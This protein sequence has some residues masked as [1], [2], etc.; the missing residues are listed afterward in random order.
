[1]V[2]EFENGALGSFEASRFATGRKNFNYFEIYGDKGAL[3]FDLE[4]MNEL[5][6]FSSDDPT[7][8]QG[9][10]T[11]LVTEPEH[12]Y[13]AAWWPPGHIIGY[14][15][16]FVHAAV[17]FLEAVD[18]GTEIRPNLHD[19]MKVMQVLDAG[20]DSAATGKRIPVK[21]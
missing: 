16:E 3:I 9:F 2:V 21:G 13:V 15:H 18:K 20:L 5:Q 12:P 10:R 6:Y 1:M 17:D 8:C 4:R 7:C 14:E 11:I 19:G